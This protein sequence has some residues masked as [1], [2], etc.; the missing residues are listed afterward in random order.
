MKEEKATGRSDAATEALK[1]GDGYLENLLLKKFQESK[2]LEQIYCDQMEWAR[3]FN[4]LIWH[5]AAILIPVTFAGIALSYQNNGTLDEA[6]LVTTAFG[7]S[8]V[9][10][11]W[12]LF[13][14]WHRRLWQ[15]AFRLAGL[16]E[17]AWHLRPA[18]QSPEKLHAHLLAHLTP[19]DWGLYLRW[20]LVSLG[21]AAWGLR[22][23]LSGS[24]KSSL[25]LSRSGWSLVLVGATILIVDT[26]ALW[27]AWRKHRTS[28]Q[29]CSK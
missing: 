27:R 24:D 13:A 6:T 25:F 21:F 18:D 17:C 1:E 19:I 15:R 28:L 9:L 3:H 20:I 10:A 23:L 16:I 4:E 12:A 11:Y 22:V 14:S 5:T 26:C 2:N 29:E 7:S 8:I